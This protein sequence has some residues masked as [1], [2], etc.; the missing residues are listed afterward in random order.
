MKKM[1]GKVSVKRQNYLSFMF[2]P[3]RKGSVHTIRINNYRTT[4]LSA[5]AIMLVALLMLTGYTLSVVR[6]NQEIKAL[7]TQE[8]NQI[9]DQKNKLEDI[10]ADQTEKLTESSELITAAA[11]AQNVTDNA[12]DQYKEEYED[13]VVSYVDKNIQTIK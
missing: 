3:H 12:I 7:H 10:L 4:L 9:L 1:T 2:V 5:T 6:Q 8:L 11:T 13:L